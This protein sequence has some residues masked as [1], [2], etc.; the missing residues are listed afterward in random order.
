M[1]AEKNAGKP[2]ILEIR[3]NSLDDGPGIRSVVFFKGCPLSCVWCHNPE[4]KLAVPEI[5]FDS[6]EC[7]GCDNCMKLCPEKA[8]S[9]G[10]R[11]FIDRTRCSLCFRCADA[12]PS[13]ALS[14][15]GREM[16][17]GEIMNTVMKDKPFYDISGG[18]VTLS[19]GEPALFMD[20]TTELLSCLKTQGI[21][22]LLE[23]CGFFD[24]GKF[25]SALLPH[26]DTVYFDI[27]LIDDDA[28]RR[29]TGAT[30]E[31]ILDNFKKL[32]DITRESSVTV[33]P[34]TPLIPGITDT[35]E[36]MEGIASFLAAL[37]IRK[38]AL[39]SYNP[40]W[41]AKADK[42]GANDPFGQEKSMTTW[43]DSA[44]LK[45]CRDPFINA[46]IGL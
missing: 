29:Y 2:L 5:A 45:R 22:T 19:G 7:V 38:A 46:G 10:N 13:E 8:L 23:T 35:D 37:G 6:K 39:I 27:K 17:I 24:M 15:V 16:E 42:I 43:M 4:G 18:G 9:R 44:R 31:R 14:R 32:V 3:G 21:H 41:H 20:F 26:L 36:N 33:L 30:N 28:H 1:G 34:R 11:Y 40:L 25:Q 12:C